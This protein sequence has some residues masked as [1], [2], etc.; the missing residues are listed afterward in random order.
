MGQQQQ[1][2]QMY[3]HHVV[4]W[5]SGGWS[6]CNLFSA[7]ITFCFPSAVW[8]CIPPI[9]APCCPFC[10]ITAPDAG[11]GFGALLGDNIFQAFIHLFCHAYVR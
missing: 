7:Y 5:L 3:A 11:L 1:Q 10:A 4:L 6:S 9:T 2:A 8:P